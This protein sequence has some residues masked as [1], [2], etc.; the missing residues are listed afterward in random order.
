VGSTN[1]IEI[2]WTPHGSTNVI[3]RA[4]W[5]HNGTCVD[6]ISVPNGGLVDSP[7][8]GTI[9]APYVDDVCFEMARGSAGI[10]RAEWTRDGR[11]YGNINVPFKPHR[12][13]DVCWYG[14]G[15]G[16]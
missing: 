10:T 2:F 1:D 9:A 5:T 15:A 6:P 16:S 12:A 13:N 14:Y 4:C 11:P 7:A 3:S 8:G